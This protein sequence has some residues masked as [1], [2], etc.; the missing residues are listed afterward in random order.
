MI[1]PSDWNLVTRGMYSNFH[2]VAANIRQVH[3]LVAF[4]T[5]LTW[6][7]VASELREKAWHSMAHD[8]P[9]MIFNS[10]VRCDKHDGKKFHRV[11]GVHTHVEARSSAIFQHQWRTML[12]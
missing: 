4:N 9:M 3:S 5:I 12:A 8:L 11:H 7:K 6:F 2:P 1:S 10:Y